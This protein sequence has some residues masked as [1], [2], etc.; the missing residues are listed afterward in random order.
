MKELCAADEVLIVSDFDGTL[1]QFSTDPDCV[2]VN[3]RA[4]DAL[5]RLAQL[6]ATKVVVLSGRDYAGLKRVSGL[7][8]PVELVGSHGAE[9]AEGFPPLKPAQQRL[10]DEVGVRLR[11]LCASYP[12]AWVED[13]PLH[14]VLHMRA[15]EDAA[16]A[17]QLAAAARQVGAGLHLGEGKCVLEFSATAITKGTWVEEH[18]GGRRVLYVGDD[19]TDE[20]ALRVLAPGD[21]GVKVGAGDSVADFRVPDVD[22]VAELLH[23]CLSMRAAW[24]AA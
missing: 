13:K 14:R 2:P 4:V 24:C 22:A 10:L 21:V 5:V 6:P 18:R 1:A 12:G 8:A 23:A 19:V 17:A 16:A 9:S 15:V 11:Q 7:G 20:N 3:R